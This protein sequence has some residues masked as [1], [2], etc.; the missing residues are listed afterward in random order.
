MGP[1][2]ALLVKVEAALGALEALADESHQH[3]AAAPVVAE[4]GTDV[5]VD[6][7]SSALCNRWQRAGQQNGTDRMWGLVGRSAL[8]TTISTHVPFSSSSAVFRTWSSVSVQ[9]RN[10]SR[11]EGGDL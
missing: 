2:S 6:L 9:G 1:K 5:S 3:L 11:R 10:R 7:G 4:R 8:V